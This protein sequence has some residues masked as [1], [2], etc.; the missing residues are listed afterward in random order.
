M[1]ESIKNIELFSKI[2]AFVAD[3]NKN[4][5][6]LEQAGF[7][8]DTELYSILKEYS[9]YKNKVGNKGVES[10]KLDLPLK[11]EYLYHNNEKVRDFFDAISDPQA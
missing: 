5:P 9:S 3:P 7:G 2:C 10:G 8:E 4:L 6:K 1:T 11:I